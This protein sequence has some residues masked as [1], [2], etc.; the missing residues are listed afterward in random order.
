MKVLTIVK[1][2]DSD[3]AEAIIYF[4]RDGGISSKRIFVPYSTPPDKV[5]I[6]KIA[7]IHE[8]AMRKLDK[9]IAEELSKSQG[10]E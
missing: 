9:M 3:G 7:E 1:S 4:R 8:E 2:L 5:P 6:S 10:S